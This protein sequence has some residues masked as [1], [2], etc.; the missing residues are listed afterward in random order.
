MK[1][2]T[3]HQADGGREEDWRSLSRAIAKLVVGIFHDGDL[4]NPSGRGR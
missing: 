2:S 4:H 3:I 1:T